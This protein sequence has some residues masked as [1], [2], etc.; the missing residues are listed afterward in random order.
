MGR[1][2]RVD[3]T[4]GQQKQATAQVDQQRGETC[5][6]THTEEN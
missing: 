2:S 5:P 4:I 1:L 6:A 3:A